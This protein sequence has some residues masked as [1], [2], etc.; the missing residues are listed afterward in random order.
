VVGSCGSK[1]LLVESGEGG[2]E[3][4]GAEIGEAPEPAG[5]GRNRSAS[6]AAERGWEGGAGRGKEEEREVI[7][8]RRV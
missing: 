5:D 6:V 3:G 1:V 2:R 7:R 8:L 4:S